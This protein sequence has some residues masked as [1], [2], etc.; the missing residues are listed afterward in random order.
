MG[1]TIEGLYKC[2]ETECSMRGRRWI[3]WGGISGR[4]KVVMIRVK[5]ENKEN[6][7]F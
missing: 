3:V 2:E 4:R 7:L 6:F 5:N 1:L